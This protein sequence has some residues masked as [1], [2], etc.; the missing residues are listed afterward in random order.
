MRPVILATTIAAIIFSSAAIA[1]QPSQATALMPDF[2]GI[3]TRPYLGPDQPVPSPGPVR[4]RPGNPGRIVGDYSNPILKPEAAEAV[5][6]Q[7]EIES[8]GVIAPNPHSRSAP[9]SNFCISSSRLAL[10]SAVCRCD[11]SLAAGDIAL[12]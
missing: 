6:K 3:W 10:S 1:Q 5:K 8:S 9:G 11:V 2:S 12:S 4:G 7:G